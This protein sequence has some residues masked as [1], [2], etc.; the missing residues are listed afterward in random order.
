[1][2]SMSIRGLDEQLLA[3]LKSQAA[4]CGSSLNALVLKLLEGAGKPLATQALKQFDDLDA[5][6]GTWSSEDA[7]AF[8]RATAAFDQIDAAQW[9]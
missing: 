7:Q 6:A 3:Q 2:A 8:S 9:Q 4:D 5:L 1:M